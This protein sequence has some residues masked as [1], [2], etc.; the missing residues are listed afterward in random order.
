MNIDADQVIVHI[1]A[2]QDQRIAELNTQLNET[3][4][5]YGASGSS[6]AQ[7]QIQQD[8]LSSNISPS[9]LSKR[10]KSKSTS[11][12]ANDSWDLVDAIEKGKIKEVD[13]QSMDKDI[14]PEPMKKLDTEERA[15]YVANKAKARKQIQA[16][17]LT[18]S[19][20]RE[21]YIAK[22]KQQHTKTQKDATISEALTSV[23]S[24]QAEEKN[25][26]LKINK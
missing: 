17:I 7:R 20:A 16:E 9:L 18:L 10:A 5:P 6:K 21:K 2:P 14:L 22:E 12:Y 25:F 1:E 11:Y 13:L 19:E 24:K 23:I 3:Y 15:K 4:V 26:T 8:S